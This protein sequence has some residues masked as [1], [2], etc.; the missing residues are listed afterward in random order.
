MWNCLSLTLE[1][2]RKWPTSAK[3]MFSSCVLFDPISTKAFFYQSSESESARF[4]ISPPPGYLFRPYCIVTQ[5][6]QT[7]G[8]PPF[9]YVSA[10]CKRAA[11]MGWRGAMAVSRSPDLQ[12]TQARKPSDSGRDLPSCVVRRTNIRRKISRFSCRG[13]RTTHDKR[14]RPQGGF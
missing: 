10:L 8:T 12:P 11:R 4:C 9:R 5:R 13:D 2:S 14:S 3:S 6:E 1:L 7:T